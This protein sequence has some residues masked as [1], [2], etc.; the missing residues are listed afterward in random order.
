MLDGHSPLHYTNGIT[1]CPG[2][3]FIQ[4]EAVAMDKL[5]LIEH[6]D[7]AR[8]ELKAVLAGLDSHTEVY[9]GW[10][11]K[12]LYAHLAGWDEAVTASLHAHA[13]RNEPGTPAVRG[14]DYYNA[15]SVATRQALS[16]EQVSKECDLAREQL[17][18]AILALPAERMQE[19]LV[20]PWGETGSVEQLIRVFVH[21][22]RLEHAKEI[23]EFRARQASG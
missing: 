5:Q 11:L 18:A 2:S 16:L 19:P 10:T 3:Q 20:F 6:L 14:I 22:D 9:P 12:E 23:R 8:Q 17:R 21:H 4:E 15:E 1:L 7:Q 13:V